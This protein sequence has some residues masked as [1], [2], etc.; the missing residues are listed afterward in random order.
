VEEARA[1]Q[2]AEGLAARLP[3]VAA[4]A[5]PALTEPALPAS[6]RTLLVD[7]PERTQVE[8][9]MGHSAPAFGTTDFDALTLVETVFGGTFTSRL[10][11]EIR[12][13]HGWSYGASC[14]IG[15]ARG[16]LWFRISFASATETAPDAIG[17]ALS[18]Y[19][20]LV[21]KGITD[22][23]LAFAHSYL[24]G[25]WPF[26]VATARAR[27]RVRTSSAVCQLPDDFGTQWPR[28]LAAVTLEDTRRATERWLQPGCVFTT[29]VATADEIRSRLD[30]LDLGEI[31]VTPFDSY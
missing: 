7:K 13:K 21:A 12:V 17:H 4:P 28:R 5:L 11:Q 20:T 10:M 23:E 8:V 9:L 14:R 3:A 25:S 6:R 27:L 18:M 19:E 29:L 30:D 26:T 22:D 1:E 2:L 24:A 31:E 15:R 16:P